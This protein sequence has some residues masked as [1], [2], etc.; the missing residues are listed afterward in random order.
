MTSLK[1]RYRGYHLF[2][3]FLLQGQFSSTNINFI[4]RFVKEVVHHSPHLIHKIM[5]IFCIQYKISNSI[6]I[7]Q[8]KGIFVGIDQ[9]GYVRNVKKRKTDGVSLRIINFGNN[10]NYTKGNEAF[11]SPHGICITILYKM[12]DEDKLSVE[13][14]MFGDYFNGLH[15]HGYLYQRYN[16]HDQIITY[17][18]FKNGLLEKIM[19]I[20]HPKLV[21]THREPIAII[22]TRYLPERVMA[23]IIH[24]PSIGFK[25]H[26]LLDIFRTQYE[27]NTK[28]SMEY[29]ISQ[30]P[31]CQGRR[32]FEFNCSRFMQY[33]GYSMSLTPMHLCEYCDQHCN[34]HHLKGKYMSKEK[35]CMILNDCSCGACNK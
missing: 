29:F 15:D 2:S 3:K 35:W 16:K 25:T 18:I 11:T 12:R 8:D 6:H 7:E 32:K 17:G 9:V 20:L 21:I 5:G 27:Q 13:K 22:R 23:F 26:T 4:L 19:D 10:I 1:T 33:N 30:E 34:Q 31:G 28:E 24:P 14:I